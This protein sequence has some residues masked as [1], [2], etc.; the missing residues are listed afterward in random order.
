MMCGLASGPSTF[1]PGSRRLEHDVLL[2]LC[3]LSILGMGHAQCS[4]ECSLFCP[5]TCDGVW[6]QVS[7]SGLRLRPLLSES[8]QLVLP[9]PVPTTT[10]ASAAIVAP[11]H[12]LSNGLLQWM[13][14]RVD[15]G[16]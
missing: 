6:V 9:T 2:L 16:K 3:F 15:A 10:T 13:H 4:Q 8:V 5:P 12:S 14:V 11:S 1:R 7:D